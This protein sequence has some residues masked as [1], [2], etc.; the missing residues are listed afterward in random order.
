MDSSSSNPQPRTIRER[1][2]AIVRVKD[3]P[4]RV[5]LAFGMGVFIAF[6]PIMGIHTILALTVAWMAQLSA[7][8]IVAGTLVNNPWTF[9]A[10]YGG[11]YWFGL[12]LTGGNVPSVRIDWS[13]MNITAFWRALEPVFWPFCV[14]SILAGIVA[15]GVAYF[16]MRSMVNAYQMGKD[17][18]GTSL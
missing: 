17:I 2:R 4:H 1:F 18:R 13:S 3:T 10:I 5:A 7:P 16:V 14:G 6:L 15:S 11:S 9:A 12:M 8:V